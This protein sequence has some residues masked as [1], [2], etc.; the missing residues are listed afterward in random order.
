MIC[1]IF[2]LKNWSVTVCNI[3]LKKKQ[4]KLNDVDELQI[5]DAFILPRSG[6]VEIGENFS[7]SK[8]YD[9]EIILDT[10]N[11]YHRF[12]NASVDINSKDQFIGGGIYEY[13]NFNNDTFNI[14]FSEFK[15]VEHLMKMNKKL[16]IVFV[17]CSR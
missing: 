13:V 1:T 17:W 4:L 5:S 10:I 15:L 14:P 9:S 16:N 8:L 11:E 3:D 12:I 2:S 7:I 6:E